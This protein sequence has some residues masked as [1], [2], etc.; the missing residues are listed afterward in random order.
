MTPLDRLTKE[1]AKLPGIGEK[2]ALRLA[3]YIVRQPSKYA[4]DLSQA[5]MGALDKLRL[6]SQCL[7]LSDLDPCAICQ[8]PKRDEAI[9]CVV[10]ESSDLMALERTRGFKGRYH[11]L[12]GVLSPLDGVGPEKLKIRELI[13]RLQ[14][15]Q[16][17]EVILATNPNVQGDATAL[18]LAKIIQ[19]IG[20]KVTKLA[21]GMPVGSDIEYIDSMTLSRAL[22]SRVNY[23]G[24]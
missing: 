17:S 19:P 4:H 21:A 7:H 16:V 10:E 9:L 2:T 15:N 18:Y 20:L 11:V 24:L 3:L 12:H 23:E 6:C 13:G 8:D 22:A 14:S 1:L 5:L